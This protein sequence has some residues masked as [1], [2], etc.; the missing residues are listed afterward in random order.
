MFLLKYQKFEG[1]LKDNY[2]SVDLS[3]VEQHSDELPAR[4]IGETLEN[5]RQALVDGKEGSLHNISLSYHYDDMKRISEENFDY[6][7]TPIAETPF[8]IGLAIPNKYGNYSLEVGDEIQ[9]N[10]YTGENLTSFFNGKWKV[11]PKW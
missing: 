3:Q 2:N 1:I 8:T 5:L 9:R 7:Y 4:T 10:K 6:Y 11:H